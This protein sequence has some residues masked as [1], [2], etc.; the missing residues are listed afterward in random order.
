MA[1]RP[2]PRLFLPRRHCACGAKLVVISG[3]VVL[4]RYAYGEKTLRAV[5][6]KGPAR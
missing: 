5:R 1:S 6:L 2:W 3:D 4:G